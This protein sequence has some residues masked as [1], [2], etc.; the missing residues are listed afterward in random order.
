MLL[1]AI[2]K[3]A[4]NCATDDRITVDDVLAGEQDA[5]DDLSRELFLARWQ[6][7]TPRE[8]DYPMAVAMPAARGSAEAARAAAFPRATA[9]S[10]QRGALIAKGCFCG[11]RSAGRSR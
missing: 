7:A 3:H 8:R 4:W 11:H 9:A 1:Q 6:R 10:I 2:G 5:F